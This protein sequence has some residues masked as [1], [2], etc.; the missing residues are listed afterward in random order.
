MTMEHKVLYTVTLVCLAIVLTFK[1][2]AMSYVDDRV[3]TYNLN[4]TRLHDTVQEL[5]PNLSKY[6]WVGDIMIVALMVFIGTYMFIKGHYITLVRM[7]C[8]IFVAFVIKLLLNT[9]TILPDPSGMCKEKEG[10]IRK[11]VFGRCNE[12]MP[13]GHMIAAFT[14]LMFSFGILPKQIWNAVLIYT[15]FLWFITIAARNHYTIDT[16]VSLFVIA[17]LVPI[18]KKI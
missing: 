3:E 16:L 6:Y 12:L 18:V 13:S 5:L 10:S 1:G 14:I 2:I 7:I 15:G 8:A 4:D 9:V 17:A 11:H